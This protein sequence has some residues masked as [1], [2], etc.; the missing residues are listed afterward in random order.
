[1]SERPELEGHVFKALKQVAHLVW[2]YHPNRSDR[3]QPGWPDWF[4]I[5]PALG[6]GQPHLMA[7]ELKAMGYDPTAEQTFVLNGMLT[8]GVD[9]GVWTPL[10]WLTGRVTREIAMLA[11]GRDR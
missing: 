2:A 7:R 11:Y 10:D 8:G 4:M 3:S 6:N 5:G 9:T 1:M